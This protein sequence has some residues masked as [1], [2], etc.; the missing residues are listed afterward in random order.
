MT[1]DDFIITIKGIINNL[2][3]GDKYVDIINCVNDVVYPNELYEYINKLSLDKNN[4][5]NILSF[6]SVLKS[7]IIITQDKYY[8]LITEADLVDDEN[9]LYHVEIHEDEYLSRLAHLIR[10]LQTK[11]NVIDNAIQKIHKNVVEKNTNDYNVFN[12]LQNNIVEIIISIYP[13]W[14]DFKPD[15]K[16]YDHIIVKHYLEINL[17]N[18]AS[19]V[20]LTKEQKKEIYYELRNSRNKKSDAVEDVIIIDEDEGAAGNNTTGI[21][22]INKIEQEMDRDSFYQNL[23]WLERQSL[24]YLFRGGE[25]PEILKTY[26]FDG[27]RMIQRRIII[28]SL[29]HFNETD[30]D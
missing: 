14:Y 28:R 30:Y 7:N 1:T 6:L 4:Y 9:V 23:P 24:S 2:L 10:Y 13:N 21:N 16:V 15:R 19:P 11:I 12:E 3:A 20:I 29:T 5:T 18:Y 22:T 25:I 26:T 17:I 27:L 8:D